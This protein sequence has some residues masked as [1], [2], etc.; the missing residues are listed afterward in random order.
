MKRILK[1]RDVRYGLA[2]FVLGTGIGIYGDHPP[3]MMLLLA[4][5][6]VSG[7]MHCQ[8][9]IVAAISPPSSRHLRA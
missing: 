5:I 8:N 6:A 2:M 1:Q 3:A 7:L 4:T 9:G